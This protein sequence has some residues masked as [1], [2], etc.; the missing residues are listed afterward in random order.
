MKKALVGLLGLIIAISGV[1]APSFAYSNTT[2]WQGNGAST[3]GNGNFQLGTEDC[4]PDAEYNGNYILWVL[5]ASAASNATI[6]LDGNG[7]LAPIQMMKRGGGSFHFVQTFDGPLIA[8]GATSASFDGRSKKANLVISHGCDTHE[9]Q[10]PGMTITKALIGPAPTKVGDVITYSITVTNS[11]DEPLHHVNVVDANATIQSCSENATPSLTAHDGTHEDDD[12]GVSYTYTCI[13]THVVTDADFWAGKVLNTADVYS[14]EDDHETSNTVE[15]PLTPNPTL[16]VL[17]TL[18]SDAPA[19]VG[20]TVT[21]NVNVANTGNVTLH[22]VSLTDANGTIDSCSTDLATTLAVGESF[23]CTISR[24][25]TDADFAAGILTNVASASSDETSKD[26][27]E[28][29]LNLYP[30]PAMSVTKTITSDPVSQVGD[31]ITYSIVVSNTGNVTLHNVSITDDNAVLDTCPASDLA[32]GASFTCTATHVVTDADFAAGQVVNVAVAHD[33]TD[34]ISDV[35]SNEAKVTLTAAPALTITKTQK[36]SVPANIGDSLV[37]EIVVTNTGNV[38]LHNVDVTDA[39]ATISNCDIPA[40]TLSV[41]ASITCT[42]TH[43]ATEADFNAGKIV[44]VAH[45]ASDETD[46]NSNEVESSLTS[47]PSMSVTKSI[48]SGSPA[49][50]GDV[51]TYS[52]TLTNTGNVTLHNVYLSDANATLGDCTVAAPVTLESGQSL[53]CVASHVTT[54][55]DF[56]A[57]QVLNTAVGNS[58][59]TTSNSNEVQTTLVSSPSL[60]VAKTQTGDL[61]AKVGDVIH[62]SIVV[63]NTGNVTLHNVVVTDANAVLDAP[64]VADSLAVGATLTCTASHTTT[65]ADFTAGQVLNTAVAGS[66]EANGNSNEVRTGLTASPALSVVKSSTGAAPVKSGDVIHYNI[67][68]TNTGNVTLTNVFVSDANAT[69]GAC[70]ATLPAT[71]AV[72]ASFSCVATHVTTDADFISG[73]VENIAVAGGD[74]LPNTNS[75]P[76]ET[77][78]TAAPGLSIS[79]VVFGAAPTKVGQNINYHVIYTNTGNITLHNVTVN[80]A[81]GTFVDCNV[82][83]VAILDRHQAVL[84]K[85][86]VGNTISC[87]VIHT[88]TIADAQ[89]GKV[90]NV[91]IAT[92]D[93]KVTASSSSGTN[94]LNSNQVVTRLR[95]TGGAGVRVINGSGFTGGSLAFTG[96]EEPLT[97]DGMLFFGMLAAIA[98]AFAVRRRMVK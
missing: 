39:N 52:I 63:S 53:T 71:L 62:Y 46:G 23:D 85:L 73:N 41:G 1:S 47:D 17:K 8:P 74:G 35:N 44:N 25:V 56:A 86:G 82:Q 96:G 20:D 28:V 48:T 18:T 22:N 65:D 72:G 95:Y 19:K 36:S 43:V 69:L 50:V 78:L 40:A 34:E 49:Q 29:D 24:V 32:V 59:E 84:T 38:T 58:D 70:T 45:A 12:L 60:S 21:Y 79:K 93:E 91:A 14:D 55:A 37:Y 88:V 13:A 10:H 6:D 42:A 15:V 89:A 30:A 11:G 64:C 76:V 4:G 75:N 66:T 33:T 98:L 94:N 97:N 26:S 92:A 51:I 3:D 16:S 67:V 57:G 83:D 54:D 61:P 81:N 5:T 90:I 77:Q 68:V 80:D 27:N 2:W 9:Q 31:S 7:P 87:H